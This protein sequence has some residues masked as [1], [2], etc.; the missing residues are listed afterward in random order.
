MYHI[1]IVNNGYQHVQ[2]RQIIQV[3]HI[4]YVKC[5][6]LLLEPHL[7]NQIVKHIFNHV[8]M[9]ILMEHVLKRIVQISQDLL[10][11]VIVKHGLLDVL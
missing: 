7:L 11:K 3:A 4:N 1:V 2:E 9:I 5:I 10:I 6:Q 8:N